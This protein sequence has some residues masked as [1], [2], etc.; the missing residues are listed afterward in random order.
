[1]KFDFF[2][3]YIKSQRINQDSLCILMSFKQYISQFQFREH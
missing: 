3:Y 1:M 2:K